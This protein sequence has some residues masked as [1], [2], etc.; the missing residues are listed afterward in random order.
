[1]VQVTGC[2][3]TQQGRHAAGIP[4]LSA[5][6][7][8]NSGTY[9]FRVTPG[10]VMT[11]LNARAQRGSTVLQQACEIHNSSCCKNFN[12]T[13][14]PDEDA[15]ATGSEDLEVEGTGLDIVTTWLQ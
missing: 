11:T 14:T 12:V 5:C 13:N 15:I 3:G 10:T 8:A 1:M 2:H 7:G 9:T 6:L 4:S